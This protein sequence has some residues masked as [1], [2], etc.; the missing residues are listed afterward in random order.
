MFGGGLVIWGMYLRTVCTPMGHGSVHPSS[1][2]P[3]LLTGLIPPRSASPSRSRSPAPGDRGY[4]RR[5]RPHLAEPCP[6]AATAGAPLS[7]LRRL[8][9]RFLFCLRHHGSDDGQIE[10]V[11]GRWLRIATCASLQ[12]PAADRHPTLPRSSPSRSRLPPG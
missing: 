12:L 9:P 11:D 10:V 2:R 1:R 3:S 7:Q 5:P 4:R 6:T 8:R